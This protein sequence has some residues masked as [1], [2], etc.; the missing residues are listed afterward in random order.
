MCQY[1]LA[2]EVWDDVLLALARLKVVANLRVRLLPRPKSLTDFL[3]FQILN[4]GRSPLIHAVISYGGVHGFSLAFN[5]RNQWVKQPRRLRLLQLLDLLNRNA[6]PISH[7]MVPR[8]WPHGYDLIIEPFVDEV[9]AFL[10]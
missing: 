8:Y 1:L 5:A 6:N 9:E 3:H 2:A 7:R 4:H 10:E